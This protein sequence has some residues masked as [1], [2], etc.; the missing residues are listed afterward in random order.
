MQIA[1]AE[2]ELEGD[3]A[4]ATESGQ[5]PAPSPKL[6]GVRRASLVSEG[7]AGLE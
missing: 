3:G 7:S 2:A 1:A 5:S 4:Q 6:A